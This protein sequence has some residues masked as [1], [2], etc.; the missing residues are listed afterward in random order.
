MTA[1]LVF[2]YTYKKVIA[3]EANE[4]L[5][6]AKDIINENDKLKQ[7]Q[8]ASYKIYTKRRR[9]KRKRKRVLLLYL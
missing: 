3:S 9:K 6:N 8:C 1:N 2:T 4:K 5:I 7:N